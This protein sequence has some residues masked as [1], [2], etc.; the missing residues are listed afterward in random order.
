MVFEM[1]PMMSVARVGRAHRKRVEKAKARTV[2]RWGRGRFIGPPRNDC[3]E[4]TRA[5]SVTKRSRANGACQAQPTALSKQFRDVPLL[6]FCP[7]FVFP[8]DF[9]RRISL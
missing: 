6:V 7:V 9:P 8:S 4:G 1:V 2:I 5:V 3:G